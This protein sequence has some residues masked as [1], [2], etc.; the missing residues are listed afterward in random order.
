MIQKIYLLIS[1]LSFLINVK[2]S[3]STSKRF[4]QSTHYNDLTENENDNN[5]NQV[6]ANMEKIPLYPGYGTHF[7][8]VSYIM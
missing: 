7:A 6:K 3:S 2:S 8:F 4:L 5:R 1:F